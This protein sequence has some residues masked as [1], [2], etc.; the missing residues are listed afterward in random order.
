MDVSVWLGTVTSE[1]SVYG[2][3]CLAGFGA[4]IMMTAAFTLIAEWISQ[5]NVNRFKKGIFAWSSYRGYD[6]YTCPYL[7]KYILYILFRISHK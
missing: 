6:D 2:A 1:Q 7:F 4:S 5:E 3:A